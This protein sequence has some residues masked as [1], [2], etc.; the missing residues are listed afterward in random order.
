[1]KDVKIFEGATV[2]FDP[3]EVK[4]GQYGPYQ[5]V[6]ITHPEFPAREYNGKSY[7]DMVIYAN[8]G[9]PETKLRK[10]MK[11]T[12]VVTDGKPAIVGGPAAAQPTTNGHTPQPSP[13]KPV[14]PGELDEEA[15][16]HLAEGVRAWAGVY[17]HARDCLLEKDVA[18]PEES[19]HAAATTILIETMRRYN[20]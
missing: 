12:V 4:E 20:R 7:N 18:L 5:S 6:K 19:V 14:H 9:A 1:M 13:W 3:G 11:V 16:K 15:R 8:P 17:V 2:V 10:G